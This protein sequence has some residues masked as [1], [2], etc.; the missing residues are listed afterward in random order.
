MHSQ[1]PS[2][3]TNRATEARR[4]RIDALLSVDPDSN[5]RT[6]P[7]PGVSRELGPR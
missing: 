7:G 2:V 1:A 6:T 3:P 5:G 4:R